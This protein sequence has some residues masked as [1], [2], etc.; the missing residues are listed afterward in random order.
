MDDL[1]NR[2]DLIKELQRIIE[3]KHIYLSPYG[4]K[5]SYINGWETCAAITSHFLMHVP[6]VDILN[7]QERQVAKVDSLILTSM[8]P[9]RI[10]KCRNC[11]SEVKTQDIY[12]SH[13]GA[14]L[15]WSNYD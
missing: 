15:K 8:P 14:K 1:I 5:N 3:M 4:D 9:Q 2:N 12:C 6:P 7:I 13:C 10:Y 11:W